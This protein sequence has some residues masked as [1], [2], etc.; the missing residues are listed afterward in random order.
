MKVFLHWFLRALG[1]M[2]LTMVIMMISEDDLEQDNIIFAAGL[3][4]GM[5]ILMGL[6]FRFLELKFIPYRRKKIQR[7]IAEIFNGKALDEEHATF[8]IEPFD[9]MTEI[10]FKLSIGQQN[11][12]W[13]HFHIP[14]EQADL[15]DRTGKLRKKPSECMGVPT[16]LVYSTNGWGL[17]LAEKRLTKRIAKATT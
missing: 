13:V 10:E 1:F 3:S 16:Y 14:K 12:E 2:V 15:S 7:K 9:L 4:V 8:R 17:K 11:F 5:A 6:V